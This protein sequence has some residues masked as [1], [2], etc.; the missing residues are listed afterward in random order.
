LN[1]K[2]LARFL[3]EDINRG[4]VTSI[5]LSKQ[6]NHCHNNCETRWNNRW[7]KVRQGNLRDEKM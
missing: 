1:T 6:K 5:I 7:R 3:A 4:D 2:E